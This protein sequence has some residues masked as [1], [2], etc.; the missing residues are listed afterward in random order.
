M[1]FV[2]KTDLKYRIVAAVL[3]RVLLAWE[4][5]LAV[6]SP[7]LTATVAAYAML[8][9]GFNLG[10]LKGNDWPHISIGMMAKLKEEE[11]P[12]LS[13]MAKESVPTYTMHKLVS[14]PGQRGLNYLAVAL[15]H[16]A[17]QERLERAIRKR[18]GDRFGKF[19]DSGKAPLVPHASIVAFKA[20]DQVK[21][22]ILIPTL[23][24][25]FVGKMVKPGFIQYW[26][27]FHLVHQDPV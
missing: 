3:D 25:Q 18:F 4:F 1:R 17:Q 19:S 11:F 24:K 23:Q 10:D 20:A 14:I 6:F 15:D 12:T 7:L 16:P 27:Q 5:D 8:D 21:V 13:T 26:H 2:D 22:A 9:Q